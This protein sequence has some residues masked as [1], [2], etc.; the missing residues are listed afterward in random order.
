MEFTDQ[1]HRSIELPQWPPH[2]IVSL[3]PSQTEL[4]FDLG[5]DEEVVGITKFCVHPRDK[6]R[7]KPRVGGTKKLDMGRIDALSPDL[8]IGNKEENDRA[9]IEELAERFPV[10]LSDISSLADALAMIRAVG[11]LVG[12]PAQAGQLA[13]DIDRLLAPT[14]TGPLHSAAYLIWYKPWMAAASDTFINS[15]LAMA[16]CKN[17]LAAKTR[18]PET[19]LEELAALQPQVV[20]LS[21]E[22]FPFQEKHVEEIREF[23]PQAVI[24]L[25]DGELFSWYGSRLLLAAPYFANLRHEIS[26]TLQNV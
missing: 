16:G 25:V 5:L 13:A 14:T 23:C 10:W 9:Q 1:L 4:L 17:V 26:L 7:S 8:I 2:R 22:P 18:Y 3:V 19:S 11:D 20:L 24:R 21:S 12:R 15:M 6:W